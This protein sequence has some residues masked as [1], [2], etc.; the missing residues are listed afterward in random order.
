[1]DIR[2]TQLILVTMPIVSVGVVVLIKKEIVWVMDFRLG[3]S[4]WNFLGSMERIQRLGATRQPSSLTFMELR[5]H[6][7]FQSLPFIW[8]VRP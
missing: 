4:V 1:M 7:D 3:Q 5:M 8:K 6:K 2:S